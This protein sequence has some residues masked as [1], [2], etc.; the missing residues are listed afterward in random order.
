MPRRQYEKGK[1]DAQ[2]NH[3]V[4]TC[5]RVHIQM[6]QVVLLCFEYLLPVCIPGTLQGYWRDRHCTG[7]TS[8]VGSGLPSKLKQISQKTNTQHKTSRVSIGKF[9]IINW[10]PRTPLPDKSGSIFR[11]SRAPTASSSELIQ[12]DYPQYNQDM[13]RPASKYMFTYSWNC[14]QILNPAR[15]NAYYIESAR[16]RQLVVTNKS[17]SQFGPNALFTVKS[18]K[19]WSSGRGP[20]FFLLSNTPLNTYQPNLIGSMPKT[21]NNEIVH[22]EP[23]KS[24]FIQKALQILW[25]LLPPP[26]LPP[27]GV[28]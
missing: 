7:Q 26:R 15:R 1:L 23:V 21:S 2:D 8:R 20:S 17:S 6:C 9:T 22:P 3:K 12:V 19:S 5:N 13:K 4:I 18:L 28:Y 25:L 24:H 11:F 16:E 10:T 27:S 14:K